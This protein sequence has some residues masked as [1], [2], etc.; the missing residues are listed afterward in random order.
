MQKKDLVTV[1]GYPLLAFIIVL[2]AALYYIRTEEAAW[3]RQYFSQTLTIAHNEAL[4]IERRL[5][6]SLSAAY[7]VG[8][9][10]TIHQG[11][12]DEFEEISAFLIKTLGGITNIQLAP[13]GIV[14]RI[15]PLA[16]HEK[17]IGHNMLSD[18][19][20]RIEAQIAIASRNLMLA[21]PFELIQGGVAVI[22]RY[23]VFLKS[24]GGTDNFWG[25]T[26][27]LIYLDDLIAVTDLPQLKD[28]GYQYQLS[29]LNPN[30]LKREVFAGQMGP[31]SDNPATVNIG[32][33]GQTWQLNISSEYQTLS[34][35]F[36]IRLALGVLTSLLAAYAVYLLARIPMR[37]RRLVA[38]R[39]VEL[40]REQN[41]AAQ[42]N[43]RLRF[44]LTATPTVI[45]SFSRKGKD[46][47]HVSFVSDNVSELL[48]YDARLIET[49]DH[50]W[51]EHIHPNDKRRVLSKL[52]IPR[53]QK[54]QTAE[55]RIRRQDG[56]YAWLRDEFQ[57]VRKENGRFQEIVGCWTDITTLKQI[58]KDLRASEKRFRD[59]VNASADWVWEVDTQSRYTY[60]SEN[61]SDLLGYA[62]EEI[63]GKTVFELMPA[64]EALRV[65]EEFADIAARKATFRDL[66]NIV[67]HKDG[68]PQNTHTSGSPI[69][70]E[71]GNL[72]GYRGI[73]K[74]V[75]ERIQRQEQLQVLSRAIEQSP[76][77]V[78]ITDTK[79]NIQFVNPKFE[80]AYGFSSEEVIGNNPRIIKSGLNSPQLYRELWETISA[81][82]EWHGELINKRKSGEF[83]WESMSISPV[84]NQQGE[85]THFVAIK[86]DIQ[87]RKELEE[88][89]RIASTVFDSAGEAIMVTD[90]Q[91]KVLK[92]NSRFTTITG[93]QEAEILGADSNILNSPKQGTSLFSDLCS[94]VGASE[95]WQGE[96]WGRRKN[97][98]SF[99]AWL[100]ITQSKDNLNQVTGYVA[101]F[102]D[103][104]HRKKAEEQ[105]WHQAN[106]DSLTKLP[107][108]ALFQDR[109]NQAITQAARNR[110]KAALLFIDLDRFKQINDKFGHDAGDQLLQE[111][112]QR[113]E[114]CVRAEDTVAR[115]G[116]DEFTVILQELEV[117][118]DVNPI[119]VKLLECLEEPFMLGDHKGYISGSIG[120]AIYPDDGTRL[121]ILLKNADIAMYRA[122]I[123]GHNCYR[124]YSA[125]MSQEDQEQHDFEFSLHEAL[126]HGHFELYYQPILDLTK[127]AGL[128]VEALLRWHHPQRGLLNA[129]DFILVAEKT[130]II[131]ALGEW[132]L[133]Q[134]AQQ[135]KSWIDQGLP[136]S[137]LSVNVSGFQ[138]KQPESAGNYN[139][140]LAATGLAGEQLV[141]EIASNTFRQGG[142]HLWHGLREVNKSN[143]CIALDHFGVGYSSLAEL[144][145]FPVGMVKMDPS[146]VQDAIHDPDSATI[147]NAILAMADQLDIKVIATGVETQE[148]LSFLEQH[149]CKFAQGFYWG[150]PMPAAEFERWLQRRSNDAPQRADP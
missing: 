66:D 84:T 109:L 15:F 74:N 46:K 10:V 11:V 64:D 44:L 9:E 38:Q 128:G 116:G 52:K 30:T 104:T 65:A 35:L 90:T 142:E 149:H 124:Y 85:M 99:P 12:L 72:I 120:I 100:V 83:F 63:L 114:S 77:S 24:S 139:R 78:V 103:I 26:S 92:V 58:E 89:Q 61:V 105:I 96:A 68:T 40:E 115:L 97:G 69:F 93:Y 29:H 150:Q 53:S 31:E 130:G 67:L 14:R 98:E 94:L 4:N 112:A 107:N 91:N 79:G 20:R 87:L 136:L 138:F 131:T 55:Y 143:I 60:A 3:D 62:P 1:Y 144:K 56:H 80:A 43:D 113:L 81:G 28:K 82:K 75:T 70:D 7:I 106:F 135:A 59:I 111:A 117:T 34:P 42:T 8:A 50:F 32:L 137:W 2:S 108:R 118:S 36:Y 141:L 23:P 13:Q 119:A 122:K 132:I 88:N 37:L 127:N 57:I 71:A 102:T 22:G 121:E 21:G 54:Y 48:G 76:V 73:D 45:Y 27:V 126:D 33:P 41:V 147:I 140:I 5:A 148:Q 6:Y 18:D 16:G 134:G 123:A 17:A 86:E 95:K 101:I 125:T 49:N 129:T 146:F 145:S 133:N 51:A 47:A 110:K 25:F 39:T 19:K